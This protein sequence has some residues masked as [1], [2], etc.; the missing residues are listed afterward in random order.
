M[1]LEKILTAAVTTA[2]NANHDSLLVAVYDASLVIKSEKT[3]RTTGSISR[4]AQVRSEDTEILP[5]LKGLLP[6]WDVWFTS[7]GV[8]A[9]KRQADWTAKFQSPLRA[10]NVPAD[11][12]PRTHVPFY[13]QP[14]REE[15]KPKRDVPRGVW[16]MGIIPKNFK[17]FSNNP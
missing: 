9:S 17:R 2:V 14:P 10:A 3:S 1:H 5:V 6:G 12:D 8:R 7:K 4:Q 15:P 16:G 11:F 13:R